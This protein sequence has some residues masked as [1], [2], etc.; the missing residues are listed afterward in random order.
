MQFDGI[1]YF[2]YK[3]TT[4]VVVELVNVMMMNKKMSQMI[5]HVEVAVC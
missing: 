3:N 5:K 1:K 4:N 2:R